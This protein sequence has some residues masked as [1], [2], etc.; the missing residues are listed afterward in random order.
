MQTA[1][2]PQQMVYLL[3]GGNIG[4]RKQHLAEARQLINEHAGTII[5]AS[6]LYET[7]AWGI[8]DQ[9]DFLNQAL[10]LQ[11]TKGPL[12]LLDTLL[13]IERTMGRRRNEKYGPRTVDIDIL[14]FGNKILDHPD[15]VIPHPRMAQRRFVL[16]PMNEIAPDLMHPIQQVSINKML[17]NCTDPLNVKKIG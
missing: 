8:E 6:S 11:T 13:D 2:T 10:A 9:P 16:V 7:A 15:L 3:I 4:D 5:K 14:F 1:I 17:A 12:D